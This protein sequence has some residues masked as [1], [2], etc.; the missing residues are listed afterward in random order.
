MRNHNGLVGR[1]AGTTGMKTGYICSSGFNVVATAERNGRR[2]VTV[3]MGAPSAA[4]RTTKSASL[5][6]HGFASS[7]WFGTQLGSLPRSAKAEPVDLRPVICGRRP[8][9]GESD[10]DTAA[11]RAGTDAPM[12]LFTNRALAFAGTNQAP[13]ALPEV[14]LPARGPARPIA[15]WLGST[16]PGARQPVTAASAAGSS[17]TGVPL[18]PRRPTL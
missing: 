14:Q 17:R 3:I 12:N 10:S 1:Y 7:G 8:P 13:A 11:V 15:V 16:P 2:L 6:E 4:E 9:S 18:P 5:L